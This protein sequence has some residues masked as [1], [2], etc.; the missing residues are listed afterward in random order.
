MSRSAVSCEHFASFAHF[1]E[2]SLCFT[3]PKTASGHA[4]PDWTPSVT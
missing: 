3:Y 1:D 4:L 2:V